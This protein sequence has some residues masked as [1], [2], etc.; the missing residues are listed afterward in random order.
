M[1]ICPD[2]R[3]EKWTESAGD[4]DSPGFCEC[5][6]LKVEP[7]RYSEEDDPEEVL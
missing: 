1:E 5:P 3:L 2:C 6:T 4:P 7:Y